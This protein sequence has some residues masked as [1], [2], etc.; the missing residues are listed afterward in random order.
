MHASK[1]RVQKLAVS[2]THAVTQRLKLLVTHTHTHTHKL[3]KLKGAAAF[4]TLPDRFSAKRASEPS[5]PS[6]KERA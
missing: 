6:P 5:A 3:L 4:Y 2:P 1:N